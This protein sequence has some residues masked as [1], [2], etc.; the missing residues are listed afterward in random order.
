MTIT[1]SS[2]TPLVAVVGATG[3]QGGSV[4]KALAE[5]NK[6]YRIRGFTRD[7]TKPAAEA[8][9]NQGVEMVQISLVVENVK[10]VYAAFAGANVA[11]L[12]TN[13]WE[14]LNVQREVDEGKM[15]IDAAKAAGVARVIWSGLNSI[16]KLSG[17]RYTH[18]YHFDGKAAVTE[19][20]RQSGVPFVDVQAGFYG[21]NFLTMVA[22]QSDGTFTIEWAVKPT[23]VMPIIDVEHDYGL[24]V[25]R[26]LELP[27]FPDGTAVYTSSEDIS[28]EDIASQLS[29]ATGK[30]VVFK[31]ITV[32]AWKTSLE[33]SG[34]PPPIVT[35]VLEA[36][37]FMDEVGYY[38]GHPSVSHEGLARPTRSWAEYAKATDWSKALA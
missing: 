36:F 3:Q 7:V 8:L 2:S 22:K 35:D 17:G 16:A 13:F 32:D 10:E 31:Q 34:T 33:A 1:Q 9:K 15:L 4:I 27:V 37:Q 19:Y 38:A 5:S 24:F 25:R 14:H 28:V 12:V 18:V 23:T 11:F 29:A 6:E 20:A 26:V 30:S 21:S